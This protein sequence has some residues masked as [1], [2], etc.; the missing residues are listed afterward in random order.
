MATYEVT[1]RFE[2]EHKSSAMG[3]CG[4]LQAALLTTPAIKGSV[5][6]VTVEGPRYVRT[7]AKDREAN[8]G[9]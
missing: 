8:L 6:D 7:P 9:E 5:S 4:R 3:F 1:L 2:A